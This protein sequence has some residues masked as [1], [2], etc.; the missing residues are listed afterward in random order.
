MTFTYFACNI[1]AGMH[2]MLAADTDRAWR[3]YERQ[4]DIDTEEQLAREAVL[5][6]AT[7]WWPAY[8]DAPLEIAEPEVIEDADLFGFAVAGP[9]DDADNYDDELAVESLDDDMEAG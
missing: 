9:N 5:D 6:D 3:E 8:A 7:E 1:T 4:E 2:A